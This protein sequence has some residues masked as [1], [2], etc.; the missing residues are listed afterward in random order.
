[1]TV[2]PGGL[3]VT[4][5]PGAVEHAPLW[6]QPWHTGSS[7]LPPTTKLP[8][9]GPASVK[10]CIAICSR[11]K[12]SWFADWHISK[13]TVRERGTTVSGIS[14]LEIKYFIPKEHVK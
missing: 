7:K 2:Q 14:G 9:V 3:D 12:S 1:M 6:F 10:T 13:R 5:E 8:V 11:L 4:V